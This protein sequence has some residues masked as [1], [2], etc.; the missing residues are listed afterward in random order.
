MTG[1][2]LVL[3][4]APLAHLASVVVEA[5]CIPVVDATGSHVPAVPDGAW[6]R[7]RPGRPAPGSGPV[8]LAEL[9]APVPDRPTWLE[10]AAPRAVPAGYAGLVLKGREAGGMC[11]EDDGL[12]ALAECPE[13]GR[14]ILDAGVG[15]DTAAAAAALGAAGVLLVEPHLGCP[16]IG[17]PAPLARRLALP[18]DEITQVVGGLR[19]AN[20]PI[21]PVLRE[22]VRGGSPWQLADGL[23]EH[24]P[25]HRL[26]LAGQGLAL[27]SELAQRY[28]SLRALLSAY[29]EAFGGWQG[30]VR[31]GVSGSA[32]NVV[33]TAASLATPH[34][35]AGVGGTVGS[36][37][38]WQEAA[39]LRRPVSGGSILAA[40]ATGQPVLADTDAVSRA[41]A[42]VPAAEKPAAPAKPETAPVVAAPVA[43]PAVKRGEPEARPAIAIIGIGCLLPGGANSAEAFWQNI[44]GERNAIGTVPAD[45]WDAA[46]YFDEDRDAPDRTYTR[47]GGFLDGFEFEPKR[48]RIP[49]KVAGQVDPVQQIT[50][51]AVADALADAGLQLDNRDKTGKPFDRARCAVIL[52]NSLGGE[53]SDQYAVR[54]AWPAV[55]EQLRSAPT[56]KALPEGDRLRVLG[57]LEAR[58][59]A[60]LPEINEDSMPGELANVIAGRIANAFDLGGANYTVDAACASSMAA[61]D[62]ACKALQNG[63]ADLCIT[64][65]A[66]RSMNIATYVKFCKIGALSPDHSAPFDDSANGFVMGEGAGIMVLKRYEDAVRD[67]DRIY[68]VIRGIGASSDGKGKGITAPNIVGQIRALERAYEAAGMKPWEVDLVEAHGTSTVVGDKVEVEA[69][70]QVIGGGRRGDRGSVRIGSVKSMIGHLKSAA[71]AASCIKT[72][73]AL[74]H[75]V[76]PPSLGFRT[77]RSDVPFDTVPLQVQTKAEPWPHTP[78]GLRRAGISA[79][80]FGGTNFHVVMESYAGQPLPS[81]RP[82]AP[83]ARQEAPAVLPPIPA[84]PPPR[85]VAVQAPV[86][87]KAPAK[88]PVAPAPSRLAP[89]APPAVS[90]PDL[91]EGIWATS[92]ADSEELA[93]NLEALIAGRPAPFEPASPLRIAAASSGA[94]E[95]EEQLQ[96]ALKAVRKGSNPDMLRGRGVHLEDGPVDGKLAMLFTGQGSQYTDM[97]L[98]LAEAYPLV[99]DTFAEA[100]RIVGPTLGKGISDF[101]RCLPGEDRDAKE[102]VL[103]RTEY[104]QPATLT[105]DVAIL[106]LLAAYGVQ[107]DMV[108]GHSLGE[109]GA[110]VA[111]GILTFE[112]ALLAVSAR[113]REM[114]NIRLDDPGK[115]AGIASNTETVEEVLADVPGYVVPANKNCPTQTVIAGA[116]DAVDEAVERFRARGITVH[117]LPV[118]HAFHS[119]I[120]APASDPLRGVLAK[121]GPQAPRR[122][123]STNVTGD[124]YPSSPDAIVDLLA[125]QISSP[126]EW[127][128]QTERMYEAGA[129][130]FVECGP[131]RALAGFTVAIL[132]RRPHRAMFTNHPKQGGVRSF[133]DA[134]AGLLAA[135]LPVRPEPGAPDLFAPTE[136]RRSTTVAIAAAAQQGEPETA[137]PTDIE[138]SILQIVADAT[139]YEK[140]E[141]DLDYE[142]EADLGVDTVKQ[143]EVFAQIRDTFQIP[144]DPDFDPSAHKTLRSLIDWAASRIGATAYVR[145][146]T[147]EVPL[148]VAEPAQLA[149]AAEPT[150]AA[151]PSAVPGTTPTLPADVIVAFLESAAE[152]GLSGEGPEAFARALLPAVQ[153]LLSAAYEASQMNLAPF[154]RT[155]AEVVCSGASIG[156]P[157]GDGVF[158][159]AN[160]VS[161]LRG[162]NRID[163]I[164]ERAQQFLEKGLVRLVK[165]AQTG[166]GSFLP[167]E[168]IEQVIRLA[169]IRK[170]FDLAEWGADSSL[171]RALD[172]TSQLAIAAGLEALRDAGIPLVRATK[173][174]ASGKTVPGPWQ[175][176]PSLQDGTAVIFASA[177]PGYDQMVEKLASNG[178]DGEGHFDRR[179]LFQV[180]SMGHSQFAQLIGAKGPNTAINAACAS[181]TQAISI[182]EDWIRLGRCERVLV[183]GADDVTSPNLLP[184]IGSGFMAAG[185]A[186]TKDVVEEAALPFDARRHGMILGMG[187]VGMVLERAD[188]AKARG[189]APV[190][191]LVASRIVNSAFHGSRLDVS[192][193]AGAMKD[194][195]A[196]A[197]RKE[198]IEPAEMAQNG[199]FMSH[200]TYTPARGGSAA[201]EIDSLRAA[202]GG[203]ADA[204][205]IANTKGF[206]GHAMGAGIEDGVAVKALQYGV[207]PPLANLR[208]PDESLGAL[209]LSRGEMRDFRYGIRLAAG[210]GSQLALTIWRAE[211]RGDERIANPAARLAW[212]RQVSGFEHVDEFVDQRT[213]RVKESTADHVL[214]IKP[215]L[216]PAEHL[217]AGGVLPPRPTVQHALAEAAA[218]A[219]RVEA[220]AKPVAVTAPVATPAAPV[221]APVAAAPAAASGGDPGEVLPALIGIIAEKTGY[222][223]D[224]LEP[225][226]ELEADLGI[227]T[228]KQAEVL[229]EITDRYGL[230]KDDDFRLADHPTIEALA[231]YVAGRMGAPAAPRPTLVEDDEPAPAPEPPAP[232]KAAPVKAAPVEAPV[233]KAAPP[234]KPPV[235]LPPSAEAPPP[236]LALAPAPAAPAGEKPDVLGTLL[237]VVAEKTGYDVEELETDFE[238]EADLG[239]DTV[240]QAEI[241]ADLREHFGFAQDDDFRLADYPTIEALAGY[242]ESQL[243]DAP[244]ATPAPPPFEA[245]DVQ[246]TVGASTRFTMGRAEDAPVRTPLTAIDPGPGD[247]DPTLE[248]LPADMDPVPAISRDDVFPADLDRHALSSSSHAQDVDGVAPLPASFRVRRPILVDRPA[249][250]VETGLNGLHVLVLGESPTAHALRQEIGLRGGTTD[251]PYN[252]VVDMSDDVLVGFRQARFLEKDR[253]ARWLTVTRMGGLDPVDAE[254][255][256]LDGARAGF[257]K[258]LGREWDETYAKVVDLPA[259]EGDL[260]VA[261]IVCD[262]LRIDGDTE[263]F[264]RAGRRRS[265]RYK[266]ENRPP[267]HRIQGQPTFLITGGARGI[268]ARIAQE[269]CERG[270][271]KLVLVGRSEV[272]DAPY[273]LEAEKANVKELLKRRGERPTPANIEKHLVPMRRA[274]EALENIEAMRATGA[275]VSYEACDTADADA[276]RALVERVTATHGTVDVCIH[277]AGVEES[278]LIREKDEGAWHRI[279]DGKAIGGRALMEALPQGTLFVS[280]GSVAGRFGN[281]GQVD[282]AAAN[283]AMARRCL[284]HP[285]ALHLDWTAWGDVG[286]AADSAM[287]RIL[288]ERGVDL[289]PAD[290]GAALLAD[291][292]AAEFR[293]ELVVAGRLGDFQTDS[294]HPLIDRIEMD[295]D[296]IRGYREMSLG[297]DPWLVDHAID[298]VP[299]LPGVIGLELMAAVAGLVQPGSTYVGARDVKFEAPVKIH[300]EQTVLLVVE[301]EPVGPHE[302]QARLIAVRA[303]RTGRIRR[304]EHFSAVIQLGLAPEIDPLPNA[305]LPDEVIGQPAIYKRFFHG[306]IFQVLTNVFGVS[307]D[308]LIAEALVEP[309]A[310]AGGLIT[311]PLALEAA[312]QSAGL[313]RLITAHVMGLPMAIGRVQFVQPPEAGQTFS[314]TVRQIG[315]AYDVDV[316]ALNT[317]LLRIRGFTLAERGPIHPDDRFPEPEGGRPKAFPTATMRSGGSVESGARADASEDPGPWLSA[318]ELAEV[319]ARGTDRRQRDRI[320]GRIAAKRALAALTGVPP[321]EMVVRTAESGEPI[322]EVPGWPTARVSVSHREGHAVA[323]AVSHG[324]IGV[325]LE[326]VEPR[327]ESFV[328]MWL[329]PEEQ[330]LAP[331]P[332]EQT[333]VWSAKEAVLKALGTGMAIAPHHVRVQAITPDAIEVS[334]VGPA[335]QRLE[336]VGGGEIRVGWCRVEGDEVLVRVDLAA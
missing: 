17:L 179:F 36:A 103:K 158:D 100:D 188:L 172:I 57:E 92:G 43:A 147:E 26:W 53:V 145:L 117:P 6:V 96:R 8:I 136:P 154:T 144:D 208:E 266:T 65:G 288:E 120:V 85:P 287:K 115:M 277:G 272:P 256:W 223:P 239:I 58:F 67:G 114:A 21:A 159:E 22:L 192:H 285:N 75:G 155:L 141:F 302:V 222:E 213:L 294:G 193:I 126:V 336:A 112:Q 3:L 86:A 93:A 27:A 199:F 325:D 215:A 233:A 29:V 297:S 331:S 34:T 60:G 80:G 170:D 248:P 62:N 33:H 90:R 104:S 212:L 284:A 50:L 160:L 334:L 47:I 134:L 198:G 307:R 305:F 94:E 220:P 95:R 296:V 173:V 275:V 163:H 270:R 225:D 88:A 157:G 59:K 82:A 221:A 315:D 246:T 108:A 119:R 30:R 77:A 195:V 69:L 174:S 187:A 83:P 133:R 153:T 254:R 7:I 262:E 216:S 89:P 312:F 130:L 44:V 68:A 23:F 152:A 263:I 151:A 196:D 110:A 55:E 11:G 123:I 268:C 122:P 165:D 143:A 186:T 15:P 273:D 28:G 264:L 101:I 249:K 79:F 217:K 326:R 138:D 242:L 261:T 191:T 4:P 226:F 171:V 309:E 289:L 164:G 180:L 31:D 240:K 66:D 292:I 70:S 265:I 311:G 231:S 14:V 329:S 319:Q 282:Y 161:I 333:L 25:L 317:P 38:L 247:V 5:G 235:E 12:V 258:A 250:P 241:L 84:P 283:D 229:S 257:T 253:P 24:G 321:L 228:V 259:E 205:T 107:P 168:D 227:D 203:A 238:L 181:T 149:T 314:V 280:M 91:P 128:A 87:A 269:F 323:A 127:V 300:G 183:I 237:K 111:A 175:L 318:D 46:L 16:E 211:A 209:R 156:L 274:N 276:T 224:E 169:G 113:G 106:R 52:G 135:G 166:A 232:V 327:S 137:V 13:P 139:G 324:R 197:A 204:I 102:E 118:S 267:S 78:D 230:A 61:I 278:R 121:L 335:L 255:A 210:F 293:G 32:A 41:R 73:L 182:A 109:Y 56:F 308:G 49:P 167:V 131:K 51:T 177:F 214:P 295:G 184:W 281:P 234:A 99:A 54:L 290:A 291:L 320:A 301:A 146:P 124:W 251:G 64:G 244:A 140:E 279:F 132:K 313:H 330:A 201:A 304:Q 35:A 71:G 9:G 298:D 236:P 97:G 271:V 42:K 328:Q 142:L 148:P 306:P 207:V 18:D 190:A 45:R 332:L 218:A 310:I 286:M 19:V 72:A 194:L 48:F 200:E 39:F 37:V 260:E 185:A 176:P 129:R 40:L 150:W 116:S 202:F 245:D 76:L 162:D 252:V 81:S 74:Y 105:L 20:S 1:G 178:D 299:V 322:A 98:D 10:S 219:A 189:I 206:T 2:I 316:D 125:Q 63:E 243:G 303:L